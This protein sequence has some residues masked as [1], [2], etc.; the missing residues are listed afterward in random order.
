MARVFHF[1]GILE[2]K[3]K[4][5][6]HVFGNIAQP[7]FTGI[8]DSGSLFTAL[9]KGY[10]NMNWVVDGIESLIFIVERVQD[11]RGKIQSDWVLM[12]PHLSKRVDTQMFLWAWSQGKYNW[13]TYKCESFLNFY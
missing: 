5:V 2:E 3:G 8:T 4:L 6:V 11:L 9:L 12:R 7:P 1:G 13:S 10:L